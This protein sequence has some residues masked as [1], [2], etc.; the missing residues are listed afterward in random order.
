MGQGN[1]H[2]WRTMGLSNRKNVLRKVAYAC[3]NQCEPVILAD[4]VATDWKDQRVASEL[5]QMGAVGSDAHLNLQVSRGVGI[6]GWGLNAQY[7]PIH[8]PKK[9]TYLDYRLM[10]LVCQVSFVTRRQ[11]DG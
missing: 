4:K 8:Y 3:I 9:L 11:G 5:D 7:L 10:I 2:Y 6:G 1:T